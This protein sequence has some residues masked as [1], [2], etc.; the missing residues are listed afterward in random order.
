MPVKRTAPLPAGAGDL[1]SK[2]P[3]FFT[4]K[5]AG[6]SDGEVSFPRASL[7]GSYDETR[8]KYKD[9]ASE[10]R[11][12][13]DDPRIPTED[14]DSFAMTDDDKVGGVLRMLL[15]VVLSF[16]AYSFG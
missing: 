5:T 9:E 10:A 7:G 13:P 11:L 16:Y 8:P 14:N 15:H 2:A 4:S 12:S 6:S 3:K 1:S